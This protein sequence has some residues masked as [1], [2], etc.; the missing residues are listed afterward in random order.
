MV[1]HTMTLNVD[2]ERKKVQLA[3][4]IIEVEE[5]K[6]TCRIELN[7]QNGE[8]KYGSKYSPIFK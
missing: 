5:N 1:P 8:L 6:E 7:Y 2:S 4:A 3:E